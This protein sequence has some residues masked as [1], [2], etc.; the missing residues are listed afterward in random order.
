MSHTSSLWKGRLIHA[1]ATTTTTSSSPCAVFFELNNKQDNYWYSGWHSFRYGDSVP[2]FA[3]LTWPIGGSFRSL[4]FLCWWFG[5][6]QW[7]R[8]DSPLIRRYQSIIKIP[9][10]MACIDDIILWRHQPTGRSLNGK[11]RT[12]NNMMS[13]VDG[14]VTSANADIF[15]TCCLW[16]VHSFLQ[17]SRIFYFVRKCAVKGYAIQWEMPQKQTAPSRLSPS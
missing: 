12:N 14:S 4:A 1:Y 7:G 6:A 2:I 9:K 3:Y 8:C 15:T 5:F 10:W 11:G 16:C 13:L 17:F